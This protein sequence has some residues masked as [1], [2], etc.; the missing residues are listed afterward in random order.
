MLRKNRLGIFPGGGGEGT[1]ILG[2]TGDVPL[3]RVPF[4]SFQLWHRVSFLSVQNW[5][6]VL[7]WAPKSGHPLSMYFADFLGH[8]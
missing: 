3:D 2:S 1:S 7:Y 5:D 6:R 8:Y 4:L